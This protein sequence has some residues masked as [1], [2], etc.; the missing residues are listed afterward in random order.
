[1]AEQF[2]PDC[3]AGTVGKAEG[4]YGVIVRTPR[5]YPF[6]APCETCERRSSE[7]LQKLGRDAAEHGERL[8]FAAMFG[9][10]LDKPETVQN[11]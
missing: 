7:A 8:A 10:S 9:H 6:D 1:M 5:G 11:G 3:G 4:G 2:C